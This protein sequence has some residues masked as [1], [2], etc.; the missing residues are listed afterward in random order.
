M[1]IIYFHMTFLYD[2]MIFRYVNVI[3]LYF[4]YHFFWWWWATCRQCTTFAESNLEPIKC[5][6]ASEH[7]TPSKI[8]TDS[9]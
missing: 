7:M 5:A 6:H 1:E 9:S 4:H 8:L 2:Y 3:F